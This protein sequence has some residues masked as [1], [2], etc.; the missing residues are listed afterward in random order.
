MLDIVGVPDVFV[1]VTA[2]AWDV[3][4]VL[5][6]VAFSGSLVGLLHP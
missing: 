5:S 1:I 2:E 3:G 4:I 6:V